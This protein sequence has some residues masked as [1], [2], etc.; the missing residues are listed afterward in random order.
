MNNIVGIEMKVTERFNHEHFL[1]TE[2]RNIAVFILHLTFYLCCHYLK[3][4]IIALIYN[5]WRCDM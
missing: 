2:P 4:Y 1:V 5:D 3:H